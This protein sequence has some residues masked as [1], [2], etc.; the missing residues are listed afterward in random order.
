MPFFLYLLDSLFSYCS[1]FIFLSIT[2]KVFVRIFLETN[3]KKRLYF[4][5][6]TVL[7]IIERVACSLLRQVQ[8]MDSIQSAYHRK[9]S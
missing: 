8:D 4:S 3:L 2:I 6:P 5:L 9:A 7:I 1:V